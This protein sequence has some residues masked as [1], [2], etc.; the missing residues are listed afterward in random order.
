MV[1]PF[2]AKVADEFLAAL[3]VAVDRARGG[4]TSDSGPAVYGAARPGTE[5]SA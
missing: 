2:H 4:A 5:R 1:S 3:A